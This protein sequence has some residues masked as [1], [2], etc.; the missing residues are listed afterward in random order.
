MPKKRLN[1][2]TAYQALEEYTQK[3]SLTSKEKQAFFDIKNRIGTL[4]KQSGWLRHAENAEVKKNLFFTRAHHYIGEKKTVLPEFTQETLNSVAKTIYYDTHQFT[5]DVLEQLLK[6][7]PILSQTPE[8]K[9]VEQKPDFNPII[10]PEKHNKIITFLRSSIHSTMVSLNPKSEIQEDLKLDAF[11]DNFFNKTSDYLLLIEILGGR[12]IKTNQALNPLRGQSTDNNSEIG[13]CAGHTQSWAM[14]IEEKGLSLKLT[15]SDEKTIEYQDNQRLFLKKE[16]NLSESFI[17]IS[18]IPKT[19]DT[20]LD[21]IN[22]TYCYGI[23]TGSN[24]R[25]GGHMMG[26]RKIPHSEIIE[27]FDANLVNPAVFNNIE[28][29]KI[30]FNYWYGNLYFEP[31][32]ENYI[33]ID[34][35]SR[36]PTSSVASIP[37][38]SPSR[39]IHKKVFYDSATDQKTQ[40]AINKVKLAAII[41]P[42]YDKA[43]L[44]EFK[45]FLNRRI[46]YTSSQ[47]NILLNITTPHRKRLKPHNNHALKTKAL[48]ALDNEIANLKKIVIPGNPQKIAALIELKNRIKYASPSQTL[49][50]VID[51]WYLAKP[52]L[53][54]LTFKAIINAKDAPLSTYEFINDF[55]A[56]HEINAA[57]IHLLQEGL[58]LKFAT[59]FHGDWSAMSSFFSKRIAIPGLPHALP[60]TLVN[61]YRCFTQLANEKNDIEQTLRSLQHSLQQQ[62]FFSRLFEK[63]EIN[64]LY[65]FFK[66]LDIHNPSSLYSITTKL[67]NFEKN[68][69]HP[70]EFSRGWQLSFQTVCTGVGVIVG[71][72][73]GVLIG[74]LIFP[75]LGTIIGLVLGAIFSQY[76]KQKLP[77]LQT[78]PLYPIAGSVIKNGTHNSSTKQFVRHL[79]IAATP[80][81]ETLHRTDKPTQPSSKEGIIFPHK[82]HHYSHPRPRF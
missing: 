3:S 20:L 67:D 50:A 72:M 69:L 68:F 60:P 78:L 14:E 7:Y 44:V 51:R 45:K 6:D 15:R 54:D 75:I 71:Y 16:I 82:T 59:I 76:F 26:I 22:S 1:L 77:N 4:L 39:K 35:I 79:A 19:L 37:E 41:N 63:S 61:V 74:T 23:H 40:I 24:S 38:L 28:E 13:L 29:F 56:N 8:E 62:S 43:T 73:L 18:A 80:A 30:W 27:F 33:Y 9:A 10:S 46:H 58:V 36:Q 53:G 25:K 70:T 11:E 52:P 81:K 2:S 5:I 66:D 32:Y 12:Y 47:L 17:N 48:L 55:R 34:R 21:G 49:Q 57:H 31:G 64:D 65:D 42:E